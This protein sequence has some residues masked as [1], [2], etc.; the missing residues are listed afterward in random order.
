MTAVHVLSEAVHVLV[1][2]HHDAGS[3]PLRTKLSWSSPP[4]ARKK[5]E[6]AYV[7]EYVYG[8]IK[9]AEQGDGLL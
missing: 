3:S 7:N 4:D 1:P 6:Y 5:A 9:R 2:D 8:G